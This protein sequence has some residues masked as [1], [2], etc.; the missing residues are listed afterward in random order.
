MYMECKLF[1]A[2]FQTGWGLLLSTCQSVYESPT[3]CAMLPTVKGQIFAV[4]FSFALFTV[5][6]FSAKL[7]P[8]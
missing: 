5:D 7:K 2:L 4:C 1:Y 8:P 3:T 6:D